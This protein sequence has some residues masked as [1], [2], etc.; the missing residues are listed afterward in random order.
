MHTQT[1]QPFPDQMLG[2]NF[3]STQ[4]IGNCNW[5]EDLDMTDLGWERFPTT[6]NYEW[7]LPQWQGQPSSFSAETISDFALAQDSPA[8]FQYPYERAEHDV[9]PDYDSA[10]ASS[11]D[12]YKMREEGHDESDFQSVSVP[13]FDT[14]AWNQPPNTPQQSINPRFIIAPRH[15]RGNST[16]ISPRTVKR[17]NLPPPIST[18]R[19]SAALRGDAP[20]FTPTSA[21][22]SPLSSQTQDGTAAADGAQKKGKSRKYSAAAVDLIEY[23]LQHPNPRSRAKR[24]KY[25]QVPSGQGNDGAGKGEPREP[26]NLSEEL[27]DASRVITSR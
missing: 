12:I 26:D 7:F 17:P 16:L 4:W 15:A 24:I 27:F 8:A 3:Q 6:E 25:G 5:V 20:V 10:F 23:R 13:G 14:F 19:G 18:S 2:G 11:R 21:T 9:F 22:I 1:Q